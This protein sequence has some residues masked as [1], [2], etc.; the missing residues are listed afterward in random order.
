MIPVAPRENTARRP[1]GPIRVL[2]EQCR[3]HS[4]SH[5]RPEPQ[6]CV[7]S[8]ESALIQKSWAKSFRMRTYRNKDL[9]SPGMN[10][11]KNR[12]G[13]GLTQCDPESCETAPSTR[14]SFRMTSLCEAKNKLPGM[15]SLHKKVGGTPSGR[16][17]VAKRIRDPRDLRLRDIISLRNSK[18]RHV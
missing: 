16:I 17:L 14:N 11:Y 2:Q 7:T 5:Q 10:T 9:K 12:T 8:L 1:E 13:R 18:G 6:F 15:I 4:R 3:P